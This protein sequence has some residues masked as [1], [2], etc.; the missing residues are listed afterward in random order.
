M[1][2][3]DESYKMTLFR[4]FLG[5]FLVV[6]VVYTAVVVANYGLTLFPIFFGD[7]IA[8][9][10]PGQFN[11]DFFGF[12]MLS[13]IWVTWRNEF[14]PFSFVLGFLALTGGMTFLPIY[15][16]FLSFKTN[17]DIRLMLLGE[18]RAAG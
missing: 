10:W 11:L 16:L 4:I 9:T 17:G 15:L 12:L 14:T 3:T 5:L 7:M 18:A 2:K 6:L 1:K 8:M 13:A